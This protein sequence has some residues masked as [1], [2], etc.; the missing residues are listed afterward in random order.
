MARKNIF[1]WPIAV[2]LTRRISVMAKI[3]LTILL[4]LCWHLKAHAWI[5]KVISVTDGDTIKVYNKEQ[6]QVKI[7]LFG[8]DSPEKRQPYGRAAKKYLASIITGARVEI[9]PVTIDSNGR[10][11]A[12]VWG[13]AANFNLKMVQAGYAW[14]YRRYCD[15]PFCDEWITIEAKARAGKSGLWKNP[16]P[17]PPWEWRRRK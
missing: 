17:V 12:I 11:V 2:I 7:R 3:I 10:T 1:L 6:G 15:K 9:E 14:V 13:S 4:V 5:A 16:N 8:I